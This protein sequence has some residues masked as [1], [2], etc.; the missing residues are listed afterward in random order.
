MSKL[1]TIQAYSIQKTMLAMAVRH[2][3]T[4]GLE[5]EGDTR[6]IASAA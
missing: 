4:G 3:E 6:G 1:T 2:V 5:L